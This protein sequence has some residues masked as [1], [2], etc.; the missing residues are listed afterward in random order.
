MVKY[1]GRHQRQHH[2]SNPPQCAKNAAFQNKKRTDFN[3]AATYGA[4]AA[5]FDDDWSAAALR[6]LRPMNLYGFSKHL[7]DLA[8]VDRFA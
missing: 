3:S 5:R 7:F 2:A 8:A 6:R 4:G 1:V